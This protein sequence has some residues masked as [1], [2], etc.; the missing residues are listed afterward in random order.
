MGD[1][2]TQGTELKHNGAGSGPGQR[3]CAQGKA[4]RCNTESGQVDRGS[5]AMEAHGVWVRIAW[6]WS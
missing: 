2:R 1:H 4:L 3:V 5:S 6:G